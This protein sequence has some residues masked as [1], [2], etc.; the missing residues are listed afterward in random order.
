MK[1]YERA[2]KAYWDAMA[3]YARLTIR[4]SEAYEPYLEICYHNLGTFYSDSHCSEKA[5]ETYA[6]A[7][8][9]LAQI[10][11]RNPDAHD[12]VFDLL[13]SVYTRICVYQTTSDAI[14]RPATMLL[15]QLT[16]LIQ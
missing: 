10:R 11:A 1:E 6:Y 5:K 14:I 8:E 4:N 13:S 3:I 16:M 12:P 2:G 15:M 7:Q 9:I